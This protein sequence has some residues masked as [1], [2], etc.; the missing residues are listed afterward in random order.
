MASGKSRRG[1]RNATML[2]IAFRHGLRASEAVD[3]RWDQ[4]DFTRA[5]L[6]VRRAKQGV[7]SVHPLSG[8]ELR[9]LRRLQRESDASAF[10]FVSGAGRA[11]HDS[12]VREDDRASRAASRPRTEGAPPACMRLCAGERRP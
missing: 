5:V 2:L 1:H 4:V 8:L 10:V 6:H 3:L 9:A 12:G 11:I 7:P